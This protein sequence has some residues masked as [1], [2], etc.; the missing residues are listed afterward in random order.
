VSLIGLRNVEFRLTDKLG[1]DI[2]QYKQKVNVVVR[3]RP[4]ID[5]EK[6]DEGELKLIEWNSTAEIVLVSSYY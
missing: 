4:L 5:R 3:V 6:D 2:D 1:M